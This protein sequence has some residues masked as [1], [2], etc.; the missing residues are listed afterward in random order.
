MTPVADDQPVPLWK[1][2]VGG[3]RWKEA[4]AECEEFGAAYKQAKET[5]GQ[6]VS[7][8]VKGVLRDFKFEGHLLPMKLEG[9]WR[10]C[11]PADRM[12]RQ[13]VT[14]QKHDHPTAEHLG[15]AKTYDAL[16]RQFYWPG[17]RAYAR[18]YVYSCLRCRAVK[19]VSVKQGGL[20]QSLQIPKRRWAQVSMEFITALPMT[21][22]QHDAIL[23][24]VDTVRK[25]AYFIPTEAAVTAEDVA[26][27]LAEKLVRYRGLPS[28]VVS[29]RDLRFVSELWE[30]FCKR[31][32]IKRAF[33]VLG[34]RN[35][36]AKRREC[37]EQS[38][39]YFAPIF[40]PMSQQGKISYEQQNWLT[41]VPCIIA[42]D[43]PRSK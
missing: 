24:P 14:Y 29:D 22:Q 13:Y 21:K 17:I 2:R 27:L 43:S 36:M 9:I 31:F 40:N 6:L 7:A 28:V 3:Y 33:S 18:T 23:T 30:P 34:I 5:P 37:T 4:L 15:I 11:V 16:A 42:Q 26:S 41:T 35:P 32:Q 39:K 19:H 38:S 20:V 25:M 8:K 10:I 12:C 1:L